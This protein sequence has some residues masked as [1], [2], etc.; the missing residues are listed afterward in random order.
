MKQSYC[1]SDI[2]I[3][4]CCW[5]PCQQLL[6]YFNINHGLCYDGFK[7]AVAKYKDYKTYY[8][9]FKA[10]NLVIKSSLRRDET[11]I[12]VP[13]VSITDPPLPLL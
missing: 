4:C 3:P 6:P 11:S 8:E 5:H 2:G 13:S 12:S 10:D 7:T 9:N 1:P